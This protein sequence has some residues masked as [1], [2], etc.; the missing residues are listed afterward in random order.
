QPNPDPPPAYTCNAQSNKVALMFIGNSGAGKS[1]LL[2]QLGGD[3]EAGVA[4]MEGLTTEV[5]EQVVTLDGSEVILIDVPG[6]FEFEDER[7]RLNAIKLTE[8]LKRGYSYKLYFI[9]SATNRG[10]SSAELL[11]MSK[12][13]DCVRQVGD[14]K[15]TFRVIV[16]HVQ[17]N[18]VFDLYDKNI[19]QDNFQTLFGKLNMKGYSF[20][21]T[22]SSV[23]LLA[24]DE[25]AIKRKA[26]KDTILSDIKLHEEAQVTLIK[27]ITV[28]NSDLT[29]FD[30]AI[31]AL[32]SPFLLVG[33]VAGLAIGLV[34][35]T[36]TLASGA[37]GG[38]GYG[39]YKGTTYV[40]KGIKKLLKSKKQD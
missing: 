24:F 22:I 25:E 27:D 34:I 28:T 31:I 18:Q 40:T 11:M 6:I 13:N 9:L 32:M 1:T 36:V 21:I 23:I 39:I 29:A 15:I 5:G 7:T 14:A 30:A 12:V 37:V 10:P 33:G 19:A 35:G 2:S 16:N 4:F 17:N 8:A 3:F 26:L 38:T 20:D